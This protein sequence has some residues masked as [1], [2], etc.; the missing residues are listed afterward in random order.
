MRA[1]AYVKPFAPWLLVCD[2]RGCTSSLEVETADIPQ[3]GVFVATGWWVGSTM[4]AYCPNCR[5]PGVRDVADPVNKLWRWIFMSLS[6]EDQL[7]YAETVYERA[8]R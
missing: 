2:A 5:E 1:T 7:A 6:P 8:N 4:R 3:L